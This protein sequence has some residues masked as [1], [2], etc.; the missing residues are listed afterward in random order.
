MP[1]CN[2]LNRFW[3]PSGNVF[4]AFVAS[5]MGVPAR[6]SDLFEGLGGVGEVRWFLGVFGR[7]FG[8]HSKTFWRILLCI[9]DVFCA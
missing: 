8:S 1:A 4:G 2:V 5:P 9:P 6:K 3:M 7:H